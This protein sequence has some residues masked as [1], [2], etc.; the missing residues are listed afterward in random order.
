[1]SWKWLKHGKSKRQNRKKWKCA[2]ARLVKKNYVYFPINSIIYRQ[3]FLVFLLICIHFNV[4]NDQ[5]P[6]NPIILLQSVSNHHGEWVH[7]T[8]NDDS[9]TDN[10]KNVKTKEKATGTTERST[11]T[12][13]FTHPLSELKPFI[14][15]FIPLCFRSWYF[16]HEQPHKAVKPWNENETKCACY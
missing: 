8:E 12:H 15:T 14:L 16:R 2:N 1:M 13:F 5:F 9:I 3:Q 11:V 4:Y 7:L 10:R 6:S